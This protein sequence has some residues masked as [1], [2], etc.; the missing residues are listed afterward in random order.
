MD[1]PRQRLLSKQRWLTW[2]GEPLVRVR[3]LA[4]LC[5]FACIASCV[6]RRCIQPRGVRST[7]HCRHAHSIQYVHI[8]ATCL[9]FI[10]CGTTGRLSNDSLLLLTADSPCCRHCHW[11]ASLTA[12]PVLATLLHPTLLPTAG[13]TAELQA[14][15]R[16]CAS[17]TLAAVCCGALRRASNRSPLHRWALQ[18]KHLSLSKNCKELRT[19]KKARP[20]TSTRPLSWQRG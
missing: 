5:L 6:C 8:T 20:T 10:V 11:L 12:A 4:C 19:R 18:Q 14:Q 13:D 2:R 15:S 9:V 3:L 17:S 1:S 7:S 16:L